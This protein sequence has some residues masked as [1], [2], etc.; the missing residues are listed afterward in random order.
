VANRGAGA[1]TAELA[2]D[3]AS[4]AAG[5]ERTWTVS[6]QHGWYDASLTLGEDP[7][8]RR[9]W[10]GHVEN[11]AESVSQPSIEV[12]ATGD[13]TLLPQPPQPSGTGS[14]PTGSLGS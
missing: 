2:G 7:A 5:T 6:S 8:F 10:M 12:A 13:L 4:L 9:R 14:L 1:V 3:S 11:G